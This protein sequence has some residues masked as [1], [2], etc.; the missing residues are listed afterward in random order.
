MNRWFRTM[1]LSV[2]SLLLHP[3]R[4]ALTV[5][6]IFIGVSGVIWLLAIGE[7]IGRAAEEQI[8]GL[9]AR[10]I[11]V[12]TIKPSSEEVDEGGYGLTR[13]DYDNLVETIATI[14][15]A[16]PIRELPQEIRYR[17][18]SF[19]GRCVGCTPDYADVTRLKCSVGRF[20][21]EADLIEERN[22][23]VLAA[24]S[25]ERLFPY[26]DPLGQEVMLDEEFYVVVGVMQPRA[27][28]A[29]VG[30]SLAAED[31]S[32]DVYI[33]LTT[34]RRRLGDMRIIT[35]PGQFQRDLYELSQITI[36]V[37]QRD[38][39][40]RTVDIVRDTI[41]R[42]HTLPDFGVTVPLELLRQA[43]TTR[44]MFILFLGMIAAVSLVV[45]GI[46]I[47]N[48]ML[49]TVTERTREIGIRRALGAKRRDIVEQFLIEA[50][51]LSVVGGLLGV[52]GGILCKPVVL[53]VRERLKD[54][55]P[56]QMSGLPDVVKNVEPILVSWS[57]PLAFVISAVV[58]VLF[59][60]YPAVRAA[61]L[62]PIEAL[63]HE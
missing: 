21:T 58:G 12:R 49:A 39:V 55:F 29:G 45:G 28:S 46:G 43:Q 20:L 40:L 22:Y 54:W 1:K 60:V 6:G 42:Q 51:V 57:I 26:G 25:A 7:G 34:M 52:L 59:G 56:E 23:C 18:R 41:E 50:V 11:I 9:G 3:L 16:I 31:Y 35:K 38:Q 4:S 48:I 47:M 36:Q 62:D 27:P 53:T 63:R 32:R 33:P 37:K 17:T 19:E 24:E 61:R 2:K 14:D 44:L 8:A 5:L 30:G 15:R 13:N 10:N